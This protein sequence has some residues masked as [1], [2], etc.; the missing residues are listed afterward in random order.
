MSTL[1][2]MSKKTLSRQKFSILS[3]VAA[4]VGVL[5]L[6]TSFAINEGPDPSATNEQLIAFGQQNAHAI[7]V[8]AWLQAV[9]PL[10]IVMF[11]FALV[12]LAGAA[13]RLSGWMTLLGSALLMFVSLVEV[14]FYMAALNTNFALMAIISIDI[15]HSIQHL[16][17]FVAAPALFIPLGLVVFSSDILPHVFG[18]LALILGA[19]FIVVGITSLYS[20]VL[21]SLDTSLAAVQALWWLAAAIVLMVRSRRLLAVIPTSQDSVR[22]DVLDSPVA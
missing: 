10:F 14:V 9:G 20:L 11:A 18:Y 6:G 7:L 5:M 16:Y 22:M 19:V 4:I 21:S 17:F 13:R 12:L 1:A 8:G 2:T 3:A 15:T